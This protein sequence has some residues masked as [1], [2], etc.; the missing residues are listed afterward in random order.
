MHTV[1]MGCRVALALMLGA[2]SLPALAARLE[3]QAGPSYMDRNPTSAVFVEGVFDARPIGHSRWSW[4]PDV[5]L[6]W[7]GGRSLA[8]YDGGR[9]TVRDDAWLLAAGA[10]IRYGEAGDWYR[11][12]FVGFQPAFNTARTQSLSSPYEFVSSVGWQGRHVSV[13]LRHVSNGNLHS[14]NRGETM[15]LIG[16]GIE[17]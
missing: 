13:Q 5:S 10:R 9:Y 6:G 1:R 12:L 15:A 8:R 11:H 3:L 16:V 4:S 14:P 17:L 2:L 7:I